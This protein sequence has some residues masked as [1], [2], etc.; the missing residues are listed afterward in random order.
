ML[1]AIINACGTLGLLV[2]ID[3]HEMGVGGDG[4]RIL[5]RVSVGA[6]YAGFAAG[7]VLLALHAAVDL[8]GRWA[9]FGAAIVTSAALWGTFALWA[10]R[11]AFIPAEELAALAELVPGFRRRLADLPQQP[12]SERR[13]GD[14]TDPRRRAGG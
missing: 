13:L 8:D 6:F 7:V 4:A 9:S 5:G 11:S 14:E 2:R 10:Y 1:A 3:R 12:S